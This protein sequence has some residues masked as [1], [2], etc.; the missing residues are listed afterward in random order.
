MNGFFLSFSGQETMIQQAYQLFKKAGNLGSWGTFFLALVWMGFARQAG[1]QCVPTSATIYVSSDDLSNVWL[2]GTSLGTSNYVSKGTGAPPPSLSLSAAQ[3]ALIN[4]SGTNCLAVRNTNTICCEMSVAW[5]MDITCG[6]GQH[7][8]MTSDQSGFINYYWDITG[9]A[10]PPNDGTGKPWYAP[11]WTNPAPGTYFKDTPVCL[12]E[13][14]WAKR[15]YDPLTGQWACALAPTQNEN[16]NPLNDSYFRECEPI[17]MVNP[18]PPPNFTLTKSVV[19][20]ISGINTSQPVTYQVVACN[21]GGAVTAT[22]T[23]RD[24][25]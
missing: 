1:A 15:I 9:A 7:S 8:Y 10:T 16:L 12:N 4:S 3:L 11:N 24:N 25:L 5:M 20:P 14:F 22:V 23:F 19:G 6:N 2:N 17:S 18:P 21:S 13:F